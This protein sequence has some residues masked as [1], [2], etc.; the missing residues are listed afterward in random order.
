VKKEALIKSEHGIFTRGFS[1]EKCNQCGKCLAGCQYGN[2]TSKQAGEIVKKIRVMPQWYPE[3][4]F[5]IRCGK[6]DHRCPVGAHPSYLMRECLEHKR[7]AEIKTPSS[8]AYSINGLGVE[9]W[10]ANFF[11]DAYKGLGTVDKRILRNWATPKKSKDILWIGCTDRMMPCAVEESHA[12]RNIAKFGGPDDCCG[13][14]AI[15]AGLFDEG[16]RIAKRFVNRILENRFERLVVGC[17]HCQKVLTSIM[18]GILGVKVPFPVI[19]IYDYFLDMIEKGSVHITK[20]VN[21]DAAISDPCFGYENGDD[22]LNAVRRLATAIGMSISEMPHNRENALC[23][24]YGG[25]HTDGKIANVVRAALIKRKDMAASGKKHI[26]SYCP[27]CHLV[28]HYFQPGY[29]SHYLL[30]NVLLALGDNV[31]KPFSTFYR[32]LAH[33]YMAWNLLRVSKSALL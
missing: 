23:C 15:Q 12:L 10:G 1:A 28:N 4:S 6:C 17:G 2:F 25:L 13:V 7:Q 24:G 5:C 27:G 29:K 3:L 9:G 31:T 16:Y 14:W 8:M 22:Y 21:M 33:P 19:S 11:K 32:R 26:I 20:P 18:P 30:E